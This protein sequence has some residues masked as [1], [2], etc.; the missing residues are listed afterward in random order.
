MSNDYTYNKELVD[1]ALKLMDDVSKIDNG[2]MARK[3]DPNA[4]TAQKAHIYKLTEMLAPAN[5]TP[6][7]RSAIVDQESRVAATNLNYLWQ[8]FVKPQYDALFNTIR[9]KLL[10]LRELEKQKRALEL[11]QYYD[12]TSDIKQYIARLMQETSDEF[13]KYLERRQ[14][15][16]FVLQSGVLGGIAF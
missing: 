6:A 4:I 10:L 14:K 16:G 3:I 11:T 7:L 13:K 15:M 5:L 12:Q 8:E 2:Q 1:A 9:P